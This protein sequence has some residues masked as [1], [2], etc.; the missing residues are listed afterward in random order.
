[1]E[2]GVRQWSGASS[3]EFF[4]SVSCMICDGKKAEIT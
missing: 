2:T 1:M 3:G 4:F